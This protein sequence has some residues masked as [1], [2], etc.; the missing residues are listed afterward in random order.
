LACT[1]FKKRFAARACCVVAA[2]GL[3]ATPRLCGAELLARFQA[4]TGGWHLGTLAV[5]NL[6]ADALLEIVV[7]YRDE[8][9]NWFLDAFN[10]DGTRLPGFPYAGGS[11][12]M[13]VS[14]TLVDID[15]DGRVEIFFTRGNK[16]V[17]LSANGAVLWSTA[18]TAANYVPNGGYQ[19]VTNGFWWSDGRT[20]RAR[21]PAT[22]VFSS[23]VSPPIVADVQANGTP[24]VL[25][26]WKID[27]DSTSTAQDFNPFIGQTYGYIEWGLTGEN[28]S[29]GVLLLDATS[30]AKNFA[31]HFHQLVESGLAL[32]QGDGDAPLE[33]YVL[34]DSDSITAFDRTGAHGVWGKGMLHKGFGKNQRLMSGTYQAGI[35]VH[36][37]DIDG[38]GRAEVFVAGTQISR[39]WQPNETILDDDGAVLWRG[40]LPQITLNNQHGWL[41]SAAL[42]PVNPDR[43]HRIDVLGFNHSHEI[44]FRYWNGVELVDHPGWPKNFAPFLPTPPVVGDVDG[45]GDEEIVV[46][47]Y[48]PSANPSDGQLLVFGLDGVLKHSVA[49]PG[50]LKHIPSLADANG[51]GT[52]DVIYRS[53]AGEVFVQNFGAG[54]PNRVSWST[55][56]GNPERD[57]NYRN[58]LFAPGTP[59]V[60]DKTSGYRS[61]TF[62]WS[63]S[64]AADVYRI[65]RAGTAAGPFGPL[66]TVTA[67]TGTFTDHGLRNGSQYFYEVEAQ[68][69]TNRLRSAPFAIM[70]LASSNLIANAGFEADDN[71]HWD[72]WF[73]DHVS[74]TN[75]T[76][77]SAAFEG[78]RAMQIKLNNSASSSTISQFNQYGIP[79][80]SIPVA[81]G[82]LYSFGG[83]LKGAGVNP[84]TEHWWEWTADK[85]ANTSARPALPWPDVFT[86]H[87]VV[88]NAVTPWLYANRAF[89]MPTGIPAIQFRHRYSVGTAATGTLLTDNAFFRRLPNSNASNWTTLV[90]F[91]AAWRFSTN[92]PPAQWAV[93]DFSV[94]SWPEGTAKFGAGSGPK[95]VTTRLAARKPAYYFRRDFVMNFA[96]PQELLL[97]ATCSGSYGGKVHPLRIFLNGEE[98]AT[99]G[100]EAVTDQG[101]DVRYYDLCAFTSLLRQGVNTIAVVLSNTWAVDYDDVAFDISLKAVPYLPAP[102]A[103]LSLQHLDSAIRIEAATPQGTIWQLRSCESVDCGRWQLLDTF[104]NSAGAVHR[105]MDDR[106]IPASATRFYQLVP[107]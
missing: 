33:T 26:G 48:N 55:H 37:A 24:L 29:G 40:W 18:V 58:A 60:T 7:P 54:D 45:G 9:G 103:K 46:G 107:L 77:T 39:L 30:G 79:E 98:L 96:E 2:I 12:Q 36:T 62:H 11:E 13:N 10:P 68:R 15:D 67:N 21:L 20:L 63:S 91:G 44:S 23:A 25:T 64:P 100:I 92:T 61:A 49:V 104:T 97:E 57:G 94:S 16:V 95:N 86:P 34:S 84:V 76:G 105:V 56:R 22:A 90:P 93:P 42:I 3:F 85:D 102:T 73:S 80:N 47:T 78:R 50:G 87:M 4:G 32:G 81:A 43:D 8:T 35:D 83:W 74:L 17:A 14:P 59:V 38:D 28:W 71:S 52:V 27:P 5:G 72:K 31:Y 88:S 19:T 106:L 41:N 89:T 69:G 101:N 6:D 1:L 70:P 82:A 66:A 65:Y 99:T 51:D 75:M 53:L